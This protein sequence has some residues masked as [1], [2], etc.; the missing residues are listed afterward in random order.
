MHA[1]THP[2]GNTEWAMRLRRAATKVPLS[3]D[4]KE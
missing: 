4:T 2:P 1:E 3:D